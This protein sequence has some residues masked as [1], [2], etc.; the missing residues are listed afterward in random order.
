MTSYYSLYA[1]DFHCTPG[2]PGGGCPP[3]QTCTSDGLACECDKCST[4]NNA[5]WN[6]DTKCTGTQHCDNG[7]C[8]QG[9]PAADPNCGI[10]YCCDAQGNMKCPDGTFCRP[11]TWTTDSSGTVHATTVACMT[12]AEYG[13]LSCKQNGF[14]GCFNTGW[15]TFW[16]DPAKLTVV[17]GGAALILLALM[18]GR[19]GRSG[20]GGQVIFAPPP[21]YGGRRR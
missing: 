8:T 1:Q 14:F 13:Q 12:D 19:G 10:K 21:S 11:K 3:N 15:S 4:Y 18:M 9:A 16:D 20:G 6:C 5:T 7:T 2:Q 17:G